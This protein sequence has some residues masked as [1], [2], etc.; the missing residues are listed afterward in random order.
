MVTF[1]GIIYYPPDVL[2]VLAVSGLTLPIVAPTLDGKRIV[3]APLDFDIVKYLFV[4]IL[5]IDRL[6]YKFPSPYE[7]FLLLAGHLLDRIAC[8]A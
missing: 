4:C 8:R 6:I 7:L 3:F 2:G 5:I 1:H